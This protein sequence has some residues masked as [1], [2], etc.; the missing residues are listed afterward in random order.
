MRTLS[1]LTIGIR[2]WLWLFVRLLM[3]WGFSL[4]TLCPAE[5]SDPKVAVFF[6]FR[7]ERVRSKFNRVIHHRRRLLFH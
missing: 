6:I 1:K 5:D 4:S 2:L 3:L 7:S